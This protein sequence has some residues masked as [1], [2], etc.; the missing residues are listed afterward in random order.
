MNA[1]PDKMF[2]SDS[3]FMKLLERRQNIDLTLVSLEIARDAYPQLEFEP[4][5]E[6]IRNRVRETSGPISRSSSEVDMVSELGACLFGQHGIRGHKDSYKTPDSTY[7][8]KVIEN[9]QGLP[10][11]LS[12]LYMAVAA[13]NGI[14]LHGVAAPK[15]FLV[16]YES[17]QGPLFLDPYDH[18]RI[19]SFDRTVQRLQT[20]TNLDENATVASLEPASQR[21]IVTR[22]LNNLKALYT[23][24][25]VWD[26]AFKVQQRILSLHP[27]SYIELRDMGWFALKSSRPG[28]AIDFFRVCRPRAPE[29]E[30]NLIDQYISQAERQLSQWN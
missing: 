11:S 22:M 6:W 28:K 8:H 27:S 15:H 21:T 24:K 5:L 29:E 9:R 23:E 16:R 4:T 26:Q 25:S 1:I 20:M 19:F 18:G 12:L 7:L 17:S 30:I 3:E 10:I 13:P 2:S 14:I